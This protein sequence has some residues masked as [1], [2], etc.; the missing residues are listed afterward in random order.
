MPQQHRTPLSQRE[1]LRQ[2]ALK[3]LKEQARQKSQPSSG[4][5]PSSIR[6][7]VIGKKLPGMELSDEA[8]KF[9]AQALKGMLHT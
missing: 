3:S 1:Q 5:Q 7:E 6:S 2:L 9:F 4:S 8:A